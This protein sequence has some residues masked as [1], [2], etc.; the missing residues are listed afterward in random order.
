MDTPG[1]WLAMIVGFG[2]GIVAGLAAARAIWVR[3]VDRLE[4][5][6]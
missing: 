1:F 3:I 2:L 4:K 6:K 5:L